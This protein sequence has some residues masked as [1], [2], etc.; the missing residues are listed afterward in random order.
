MLVTRP[1]PDASETVVRLGALGIEGMACPLLVHQTLPA[2]LPEADGFAAMALTSTNALRALRERGVLE[3]YLKLPVYAVGSRTAA[4]ARSLGFR[5][6]THAAGGNFTALAELLAHAPLDGPIF[7]PGAR[8]L[9]GD[10]AKTL[11]PFGRMVIT[12]EVYAMNPVET[13]PL[14]AA[15]GFASGSIGAVLLYSKR[16]AETFVRLAEPHIDRLERRQLGMLCL[17]E[18]VAAPLF[19]A[20]FVRV[21]LAE[22]PSEPAMMSLALSFARDQNAS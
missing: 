8:E 12:A 5:Q 16:T 6:V 9:A 7:Y 15:G 11:A 17:S 14:T 22:H 20:H 19:D 13:L 4:A 10:L 18:A 1:E 3:R 21:C 2:S